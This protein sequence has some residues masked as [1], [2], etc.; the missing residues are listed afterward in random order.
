MRCT[1]VWVGSRSWWWTGKPD[2]LQSMGMQRVGHD[3]A[4]E[5]TDWLKIMTSLFIL[6]DLQVFHSQRYFLDHSLTPKRLQ[7]MSLHHKAFE[8]VCVHA[9]LLQLCLTLC[10]PMDCSPPASSVHGILQVRILEG[11][12][13]PFSW[14]SSRP[15]DRTQVSC[16]ADRLFTVR[17]TRGDHVQ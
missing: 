12:A 3:W 15:R 14:G 7:S 8:R 2:M 16:T 11:I 6:N 4:T 17:A 10:D 1:C 9:K 5:V 13:I